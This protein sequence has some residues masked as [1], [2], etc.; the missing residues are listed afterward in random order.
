[1][2]LRRATYDRE[3]KAL[4]VY[5]EESSGSGLKT[6]QLDVFP[7]VNLDSRRDWRT[8]DVTILGLEI[9]NVEL[10]DITRESA[11]LPEITKAY[12]K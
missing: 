1:M 3:A 10:E 9:L 5:V 2:V 7:G 8:G 6:L 11:D 12:S 4:Y